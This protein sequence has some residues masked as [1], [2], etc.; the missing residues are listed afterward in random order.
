MK[1]D[2]NPFYPS[3]HAAVCFVHKK[4]ECH[5]RRMTSHSL[6]ICQFLV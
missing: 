1:G 2:H 3:F 5:L 6:K 4:N